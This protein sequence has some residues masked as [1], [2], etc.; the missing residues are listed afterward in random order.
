[1]RDVKVATHLVRTFIAPTETFIYT[2]LTHL[3]RH[4]A[5]VVSRDVENLDRFPGVEHVAFAQQARGVPRTISDLLYRRLRVQSAYE[6]GFYEHAIA[7]VRPTLIHLHYAVDAAYFAPVLRR[8]AGPVV[9]SCYGYDVSSFAQR[10]RGLGRRY[11]QACWPVADCVLAMSDD[12]R[13]DLIRLGCPPSKIR[14]HYHGVN[15]ERFPYQPRPGAPDA[16]RILFVG[17]LGDERKGVEDLIRSFAA[18]REQ[19]PGVE[20]RIVGDGPLRPRY[21][22]LARSLGLH[23]AVTFAGFVPHQDLWQEYGAARV[24]CHPSL[25][26][27]DGDKEG[28]PGTIVEA[29]ATGLPVVTTRHAGIPEMVLDGEHGFVVAERDHAAI[30]AALRR[31]VDDPTLRARLGAQAATRARGRGDAVRQTAALEAIYDDVLTAVGRGL[32]RE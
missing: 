6:R 24:F 3:R 1:M 18:L 16:V 21:E 2:Q 10:Y 30:A 31:L 4:R 17:S 14:V 5:V 25:T 28:I 26:P 20:L 8:V 13:H 19:R 29:M 23:G 15:L 22:T 32:D 11:L 12:M 27:P 7:S 9:V